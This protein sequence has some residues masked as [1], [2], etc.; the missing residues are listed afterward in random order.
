MPFVNTWPLELAVRVIPEGLLGTPSRCDCVA[1][2]VM[3]NDTTPL[4]MA[5]LE[6]E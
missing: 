4:E 6:M 5:T 3:V 2:Q 1:S